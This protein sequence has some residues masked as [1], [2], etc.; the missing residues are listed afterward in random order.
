MY[1]LKVHNEKE[2][3]KDEDFIESESEITKCYCK[4]CPAK[5]KDSN[6]LQMHIYENHNRKTSKKKE[7]NKKK[8]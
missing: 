2:H 8:P 6:E 1:L 4:N 7:G 5:F 3:S